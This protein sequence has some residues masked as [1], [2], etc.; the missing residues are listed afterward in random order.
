MR[1]K[2]LSALAVVASVLV[3]VRFFEGLAL[4]IRFGTIASL[5]NSRMGVPAERA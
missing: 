5:L 4:S 1:P 2:L 3:A